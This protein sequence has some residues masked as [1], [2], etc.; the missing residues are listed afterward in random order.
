MLH[1]PSYNSDLVETSLK[2]G[3]DNV[4]TKSY[5][6][7][8]G[9]LRKVV[10][11]DETQ[12][13]NHYNSNDAYIT[14]LDNVTGSLTQ[15]TYNSAKKVNTICKMSGT[16]VAEVLENCT[17]D[18]YGNL[19]THNITGAVNNSY[20][21]YYKNNTARELDYI[22]LPNNLRS[23]A[24]KDVNGRLS[25]KLL[26]DNNGNMF[27]GEY[28]Y[29]RKTG[30][31]ATKQVSSIRYGLGGN[32]SE[33]LKYKYDSCGNISE[34]YEN[35]SF[36]TRYTYDK[37]NRL[38]RE[39]N[40]VLGN[41]Y[42]FSYDN[43][44]N[45]L[46]K[47]KVNYTLKDLDEISFEG[48]DAVEVLYKYDTVHKD[49]LKAFGSYEIGYDDSVNNIG[50]PKT[51]RGNNLTW[52]KGRQLVGYGSIQ[53][54]YDGYGRRIKKGNTVFTYN[55]EGILLKQS[56]G[57]NTWEF[58]YDATGL[59]GFKYNGTNYLY[60]KNIQGDI[61]HIIDLS[62]NIAVKYAYDAWGNY[63]VLKD[64][65]NLAEINPFRYRG[66]YY[67]TETG[68]YSVGLRYYDPEVG[69]WINADSIDNAMLQIDQINGLNLYAFCLNNPVNYSDPTGG[70]V[71]SLTAL[72]LIGF[73]V[74]TAIGAG[75][76]IISQGID[77]GWG[78]I[79]WWQV[80]LDGLLGGVGGALMMTGL[81]TVAM[82]GIGAGLGFVGSVGGH[83]LNGSDFGSWQTWLDIGIS[84]VIGGV[85][86]AIGGRGATN[87]GYLNGA[88]RSAGF[89]KAA[90]SYDKVLTKIAA[91]GY[92]NLAG[93]AGA[94]Y[95]TGR[96]LTTAWSQMIVSQAGRALTSSLIKTGVS[97]FTL[98]IGRSLIYNWIGW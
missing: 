74:G 35:G 80:G 32:I 48:S 12:V 88:P 67:D 25:E 85:A 96:A 17:Y 23:Y 95:L 3:S 10:I 49:R 81:G 30:D 77:K 19:S 89:L 40:K 28:Y 66:Y 75:A 55:A 16:N 26:K 87:A 53:F 59:A 64:T 63:A 72:I 24:N 58:V 82:A 20:Q 84:T 31:H 37:L 29:Y 22:L 78:N 79:N 62:G 47:R 44:G 1:F 93:A 54:V 4:V 51:Y 97:M 70:F 61:T 7:K 2:V 18:G 91:G 60:R 13:A 69:R 45:I 38:V 15:F 11:N 90:A 86:G 50:N 57:I 65:N 94:R 34:V 73:G 41:T 36:I 52:A 76:S 33:G 46:S 8:R 9:N 27:A 92:K 83:L 5:K 21:Y 39:D 42:L 6:D 71:L 43:N 56:N 14:S 68:L 98:N